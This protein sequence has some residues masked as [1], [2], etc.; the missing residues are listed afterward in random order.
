[1]YKAGLV[2]SLATVPALCRVP[3]PQLIVVSY[4]PGVPAGSAVNCA[5]AT[6]ISGLPS[7][8]ARGGVGV[9]TMTT[10][11]GG[12][13]TML[14]RSKFWKTTV[15]EPGRVMVVWPGSGPGVTTTA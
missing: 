10:V 1:M 6:S 4:W 9:T 13:V 8:A 7:T 2:G 11:G 3:S 15:P 14:T 12:E 5:T